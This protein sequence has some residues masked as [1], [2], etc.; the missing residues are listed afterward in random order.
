MT[1]TAAQLGAT[2]TTAFDPTGLDADGQLTTPY[3][4]AVLT[5]AALD[6]PEIRRAAGLSSVT[7]TG[8]DGRARRADQQQSP[9]RALPG[10]LGVKT[11]STADAGQTFVGAAER[12]GRTLAV[13]LMQAPSAFGTEATRLLDWGFSA[14]GTTSGIGVLPPPPGAVPAPRSPRTNLRSSRRPRTGVASA[15]CSP[16]RW[17]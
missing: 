2:D 16:S 11:G 15:P 13:V 3:D 7:F 12:D 9:A 1:A 17:P 8:S 4:L 14:A 10:A 6:R 5:R